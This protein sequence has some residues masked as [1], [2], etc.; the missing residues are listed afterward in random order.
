MKKSE[1]IGACCLFRHACECSPKV[2]AGISCF[3]LLDS[4]LMPFCLL[5][6]SGFIILANFIALVINLL[7]PTSEINLLCSLHI[8]DLAFGVTLASIAVVDIAYR[9]NFI[10][11]VFEWQQHWLCKLIATLAFVS[12][13]GSLLV[14]LYTVVKRVKTIQQMAVKSKEMQ[15]TKGCFAIFVALL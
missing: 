2:N 15:G 14:L 7:N 9:D 6:E 12:S 8:A 1:I 13:E 10:A 3:N 4:F 5:V 11:L